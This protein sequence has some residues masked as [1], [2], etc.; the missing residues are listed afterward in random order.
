[1]FVG[2]GVGLVWFF[3]EKEAW[4]DDLHLH[5]GKKRQKNCESEDSLGYIGRPCHKKQKAMIKYFFY[6]PF[7]TIIVF[8]SHF[9]LLFCDAVPIAQIDQDW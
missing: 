8:R 2:G 3:E 1:M 7:F 6:I 4:V 5:K 9:I